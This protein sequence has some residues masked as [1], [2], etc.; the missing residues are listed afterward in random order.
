MSHTSE[1]TP[2]RS[3][4]DLF[5]QQIVWW[6]AVALVLTKLTFL[7]PLPAAA[8]VTIRVWREGKTPLYLALVGATAGALV[9]TALVRR[10]AIHF[11]SDPSGAFTTPWMIGLW[12]AFAIAFSGSMTWLLRRNALF[13]G[14][15]G[16]SAGVLAYRAGDSLGILTIGD[17]AASL[18][19]IA[20]G[21]AGAIL[22]IRFVAKELI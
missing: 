10:G 1:A 19:A 8:Y 14:V 7:A 15:F 2:Y 5:A 16:A 3:L 4:T 12:G 6:A 13:A 22:V 9:D 17:G 21:W 20:W 11:P 18:F